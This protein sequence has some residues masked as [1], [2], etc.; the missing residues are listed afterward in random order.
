[1]W[2]IHLLLIM[3]NDALIVLDFLVFSS[4][5]QIGHQVKWY[6]YALRF[7]L[8]LIKKF[9]SHDIGGPMAIPFRGFSRVLGPLPPLPL[10]NSL[11]ALLMFF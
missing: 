4:N 6:D 1:M 9:Y 2:T 10:N 7:L 3:S 11:G 8:S 5:I